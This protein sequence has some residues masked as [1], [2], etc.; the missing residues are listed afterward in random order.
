V[1]LM[2]KRRALKVLIAKYKVPVWR[3]FLLNVG[4]RLLSTNYEVQSTCM[5]VVLVSEPYA[6]AN[7]VRSIAHRNDQ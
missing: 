2:R 3:C 6:K 5:A 7:V 1:S 4:M